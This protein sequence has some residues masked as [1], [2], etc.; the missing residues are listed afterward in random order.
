MNLLCATA[1]MNTAVHH[2]TNISGRTLVAPSPTVSGELNYTSKHRFTLMVY[3]V[4]YII[5]LIKHDRYNNSTF[6][7]FEFRT[8]FDIILYCQ[9]S[10]Y[11]DAKVQNQHK[12]FQQ[13]VFRRINKINC[14]VVEFYFSCNF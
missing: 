7:V 12:T 5:N 13:I 1:V 6:V 11:Y 14:V 4:W 9:K 3:F 10:A 2:I 8:C